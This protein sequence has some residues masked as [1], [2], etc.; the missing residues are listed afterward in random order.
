ME[1]N[2]RYAVRVSDRAHFFDGAKWGSFPLHRP[3]ERRVELQASRRLRQRRQAARVLLT[4]DQMSDHKGARLMLDALPPAS[5]M[6]ADRVMTATGSAR[7]SR[8]VGQ[9]PAFHLPKAAGR[10]SITIRLYCHRHKIENLFA[11]LKD[12]RRIATRYDRCAHAFFSAIRIAAAV[13]FYLNQ[14]VLSL[15]LSWIG[16]PCRRH[17]RSLVIWR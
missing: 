9:S 1:F 12:L 7:R 5:V 15:V 6:I 14:R 16:R 8:S 2:W 11:K 13:A 3:H 4:E 10:H 17:R